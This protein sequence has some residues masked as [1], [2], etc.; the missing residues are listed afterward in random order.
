MYLA[1]KICHK[2]AEHQK[3]TSW[4]TAQLMCTAQCAKKTVQLHIS[5]A[6]SGMGLGEFSSL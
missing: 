2:G 1:L 3:Y 6:T 5:K 4:E